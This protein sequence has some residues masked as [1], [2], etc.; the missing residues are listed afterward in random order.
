MIKVRRK[1]KYINKVDNKTHFILVKLLMAVLILEAYFIFNYFSGDSLLSSIKILTKE[2]NSTSYGE[3]F[4][5]FVDNAQ[6]MLLM[7]QN[8]SVLNG[9]SL[10]ASLQNINKLYLLDSE[11]LQQHS[12]NIE[13]HADSYKNAFM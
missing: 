3:S 6:R 8:F 1:K 9:P 10:S 12:Q 13:L 2:L 11:V 5:L 4:Y 7:D